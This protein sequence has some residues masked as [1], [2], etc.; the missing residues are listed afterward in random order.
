MLQCHIVVTIG[1]EKARR[2]WGSPRQFEPEGSTMRVGV[3]VLI[4]A[5]AICGP[6]MGEEQLEGDALRKA[7]AGKT[8]S[9]ETPLGGLPINFRHNGTMHSKTEELAYYTGSTQ[10]HGVWWVA[11]NKLCQRWNNWLGGKAYCFTLRQAGR[12]VQ[13]TRNDGLSGVATIRR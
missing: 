1:L 4:S 9:L 13:W 7:V 8:V 6:A 11:A 5:L 2:V 10:D 12:T 3:I